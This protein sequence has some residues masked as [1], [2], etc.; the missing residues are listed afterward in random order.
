M[1]IGFSC[2]SSESVSASTVSEVAFEDSD[3]ETS[4]VLSDAESVVV[5]VCVSISEEVSV[6]EFVVSSDVSESVLV[7]VLVSISD[8]VLSSVSVV[9]VTVSEVS[10]SVA[11]SVEMSDVEEFDTE[12][13]FSSQESDVE[14]PVLSTNSEVFV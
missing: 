1:L 5:D 8:L 3:W 10:E 12:S 4:V 2:E 11:L 13:V 14:V 9:V 6:T 7:E